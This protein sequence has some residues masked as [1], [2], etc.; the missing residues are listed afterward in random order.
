MYKICPTFPHTGCTSS[1][2]HVLRLT[3]RFVGCLLQLYTLSLHSV[4]ETTS[5]L[6][7]FAGRSPKPVAKTNTF[8]K[9]MGHQDASGYFLVLLSDLFNW[10]LGCPNFGKA[11][12]VLLFSIF[13][14]SEAAAA[15]TNLQPVGNPAM[16][17]ECTFPS[18]TWSVPSTFCNAVWVALCSSLSFHEPCFPNAEWSNGLVCFNS[19]MAIR[20]LKLPLSHVHVKFNETLCQ[21][22]P[23][24]MACVVSQTTMT[25]NS[26]MPVR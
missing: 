12:L 15:A 13:E 20:G 3:K 22:L 10:V 21:W 25:P 17:P 19:W 26:W 4:R 7:W 8:F 23:N 6:Y 11:P 18:I 1:V 16:K 5:W 9:P 14:I 2:L 24:Y